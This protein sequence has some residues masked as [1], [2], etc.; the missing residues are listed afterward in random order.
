MTPTTVKRIAYLFIAILM[1]IAIYPF[2]KNSFYSPEFTE[3]AILGKTGIIGEN[4]NQVQLG[5]ELPLKIYIENHERQTMLYRIVIK[6][7]E[8]VTLEDNSPPFSVKPI[9]S[10]LIVLGDNEN[11]TYPF[12]V[13]IDQPFNGK[14]VAELYRFDSSATTFLYH[15]RWVAIWMKTTS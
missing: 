14:L 1:I 13:V 8:N 2:I 11:T 7:V 12:K 10:Y 9:L 6:L 15:D 3:I 5:E 4:P